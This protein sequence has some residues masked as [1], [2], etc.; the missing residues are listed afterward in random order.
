MAT[1]EC[2]HSSNNDICRVCRHMKLITRNSLLLRQWNWIW[3][4][5]QEKCARLRASGCAALPLRGHWQHWLI[6]C[7]LLLRAYYIYYMHDARDAQRAICVPPCL[8]PVPWHC[9]VWY[10]SVLLLSSDIIYLLRHTRPVHQIKSASRLRLLTYFS[11]LYRR[12]VLRYWPSVSWCG[13]PRVGGDR[14]GGKPFF[15]F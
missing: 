2:R 11:I 5:I 10:L 1:S 12:I 4:I 8:Q 15:M 13:A 7:L 9:T 3:Y 14:N 6:Y